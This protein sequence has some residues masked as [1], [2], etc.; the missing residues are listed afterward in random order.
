MARSFLILGTIILHAGCGLERKNMNPRPEQLACRALDRSPASAADCLAHSR[1]YF[2]AFCTFFGDGPERRRDSSA[3]RSIQVEAANAVSP[4]SARA[5]VPAI[6][7]AN[8]PLVTNFGLGCNNAI[9][10]EFPIGFSHPI[11]IAQDYSAQ[12][13]Q[14]HADA[15]LDE[16]REPQ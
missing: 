11:S 15:R 4:A 14:R 13:C 10:P 5:I 16:V 12:I 9:P 7:K 8:R 2:L 6:V 3:S 1:W